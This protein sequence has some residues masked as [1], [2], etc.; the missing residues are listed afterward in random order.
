MGSVHLPLIPTQYP[1]THL[2]ESSKACLRGPQLHKDDVPFSPNAIAWDEPFDET[3]MHTST[4]S[5]PMDLWSIFVNQDMMGPP[6]HIQPL[7][8]RVQASAF[9]L[10]DSS[11]YAFVPTFPQPDNIPVDFVTMQDQSD[12]DALFLPI[13]QH[14]TRSCVEAKDDMQ[15]IS[16]ES[17]SSR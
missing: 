16:Q 15:S 1:D 4:S 13:S 10:Q 9:R 17:L 11:H 6:S 12:V 7:Q 8:P 14:T 2:L 5:S 3:P